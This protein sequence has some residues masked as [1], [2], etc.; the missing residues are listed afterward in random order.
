MARRTGVSKGRQGRSPR[1]S[2]TTS[3]EAHDTEMLRRVRS[4]R[5]GEQLP[6]VVFATHVELARH[7]AVSLLED[8]KKR[9]RHLRPIA[10]RARQR[11]SYAGTEFTQA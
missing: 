11:G 4:A 8:L 3:H 10:N 1:S 5:E 9:G 7:M 6:F 2:E